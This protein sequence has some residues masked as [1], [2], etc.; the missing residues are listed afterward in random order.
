[1]LIVHLF[2]SYAHVNL[3]HLF[4]SSWCQG[5]DTTSACGSFWT[6][7]FIVFKNN[8]KM[9][10]MCFF[11]RSFLSLYALFHVKDTDC[12][13][14]LIKLNHR[15]N[16]ASSLTSKRHHLDTICNATSRWTMIMLI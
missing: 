13:K 7:L 1:M 9:A 10:N 8:A 11:V 16:K 15:Q 2:V 5:L 3:C 14:D 12:V 4:S 6:F